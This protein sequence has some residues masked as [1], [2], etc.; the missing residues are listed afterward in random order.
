MKL[1]NEIKDFAKDHKISFEAIPII[2]ATIAV[3]DLAK[4]LLDAMFAKFGLSKDGS[5]LILAVHFFIICGIAFIAW[6]LFKWYK[7]KRAQS[8]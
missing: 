8:D 7:D 6:K 5:L 4:G 1:K 3:N 2:W